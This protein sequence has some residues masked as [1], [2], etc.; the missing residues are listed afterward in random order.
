MNQYPLAAHFADASEKIK[1]HGKDHN[2]SNDELLN[3]YG[4]FKQANEGDNTTDRPGMLYFEKKAKWDAWTSQKGKS[5]D[6]A[7]HE[8]VTIAMKYLPEDV[9]KNYA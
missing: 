5:A 1:V 9:K 8:Y 6:Q 3:L 4:L 2:L 7:K